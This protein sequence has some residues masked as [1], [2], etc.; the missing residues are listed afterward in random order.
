V[1]NLKASGHPDCD[2]PLECREIINLTTSGDAPHE[3]PKLLAHLVL[4]IAQ[5]SE[6]ST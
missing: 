5:F 2:E 3:Q 6:A 4:A 1:S